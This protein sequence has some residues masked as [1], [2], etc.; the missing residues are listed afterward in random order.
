MGGEENRRVGKDSLPMRRH[1]LGLDV[2]LLVAWSRLGPAPPPPCPPSH[3][4]SSLTLLPAP[5]PT[6]DTQHQVEDEEGPQQNEG[7]KVDPGPLIPDGI[8]DL[9]RWK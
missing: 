7:D 2:S 5:L 9:A 8:V 4:S 6:Q 3:P 1:F